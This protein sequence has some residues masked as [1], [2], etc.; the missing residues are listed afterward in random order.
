MKLYNYLDDYRLDVVD[1]CPHNELDIDGKR[2]FEKN[3]FPLDIS[4]FSNGTFN[5][6][7]SF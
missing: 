2:I 5:T 1:C 4:N 6:F 3:T 7:E